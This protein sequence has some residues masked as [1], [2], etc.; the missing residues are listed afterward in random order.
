[1][2][3]KR[4]PGGLCYILHQMPCFN[5]LVS[6]LLG[7][8]ALACKPTFL[9]CEH[10]IG[11]HQS[12]ETGK[13]LQVMNF[14]IPT[15]WSSVAFQGKCAFAISETS[16]YNLISGFAYWKAPSS[17]AEH[18]LMVLINMQWQLYFFIWFYILFYFILLCFALFVF[19]ELIHRFH[20]ALCFNLWYRIV[21]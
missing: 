1:M 14:C 19:C 7:P 13:F 5:W 15:N 12:P 8:S 18:L 20:Q 10:H 4:W 16:Q 3:I 6:F 17:W 2:I 9:L 21:I 11:V